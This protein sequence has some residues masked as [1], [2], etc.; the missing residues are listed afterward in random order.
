[1]YLVKKQLSKQHDILEL[2]RIKCEE[3]GYNR[4]YKDELRQSL[5][6]KY[7]ENPSIYDNVHNLAGYIFLQASRV[8]YK[9]AKEEGKNYALNKKQKQLLKV[10]EY[11]TIDL[12]GIDKVKTLENMIK[13]LPDI[14]KIWIRLYIDCG[15]NYSEIQR[16]TEITRQCAK[17]RIETILDKWKHLDIYLD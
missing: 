15:M 2:I 13:E 12:E 11:L 17:D 4:F 5:S 10:S 1:M 3:I 9:I 8:Q 14:E 6:L 16:R 7:L